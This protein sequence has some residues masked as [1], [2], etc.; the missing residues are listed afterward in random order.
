M[1]YGGNA[2]YYGAAD[3]ISLLTSLAANAQGVTYT[4]AFDGAAAAYSA[5]FAPPPSPLPRGGPL[6]CGRGRAP[7]ASERGSS[8]G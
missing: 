7:L 5:G 1:L 4:V 2:T 8:P 3:T 6:R